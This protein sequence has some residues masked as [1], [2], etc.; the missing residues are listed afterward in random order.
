MKAGKKN[1]T[2]ETHEIGSEK[3]L[4]QILP[5]L[6]PS[7][8]NSAILKKAAEKK[9]VTQFPRWAVNVV[10]KVYAEDINQTY[11][12][13]QYFCNRIAMRWGSMRLI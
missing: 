9:E 4:A 2:S 8:Q 6:K 7:F 10:T 11:T 1:M 12:Q 3:P 5:V 13:K